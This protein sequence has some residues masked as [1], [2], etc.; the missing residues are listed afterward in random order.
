MC[1]FSASFIQTYSLHGNQKIFFAAL[2]MG[3]NSIETFMQNICAAF[4]KKN[5]GQESSGELC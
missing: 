5:G 1:W 4:W 3:G 2:L